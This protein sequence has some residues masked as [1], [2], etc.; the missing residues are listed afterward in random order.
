MRGVRVFEIA[1]PYACQE[2]PLQDCP[3][4]RPLD[5]AQLA[6]MQ[7]VKEAEFSCER[8]DIVLKEGDETDHLFTVL[9]G[10]AIR[11]LELEDGRR[12][13]I[14]FMFPGDLI[15]LQGAFDEPL[16][17]SVE[18]VLPLR[19]CRFRRS[20]FVHLI[21]EHPRL[22]FDITWLAAKEEN[23]LEGH[24]VSL[25]QRSARERVVYLAAWLLDR[26][27]ATGI[28]REGNKLSMAITQSQIADM[29]GLS[30]VHTNRTI[31]S[32]DRD[33]LVE[34]SSREIC[35]PDMAKAAKFASFER[36][37]TGHRPFV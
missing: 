31:K 22:G 2:C 28:A 15:G 14:N 30:L 16:S 27:L 32:L 10:V 17:H 34:W 37:E 5:D 25:G 20:D 24:I 4:L 36:S 7:S 1:E 26:A 19:L 23:A 33:G 35:V 11:Y 8:G 21:K 3:G 29:L 12:Q 9:D 6:Y 18:A 13:I